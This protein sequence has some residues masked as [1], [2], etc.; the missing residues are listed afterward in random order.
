MEATK[1]F[2]KRLDE[3]YREE[4]SPELKARD[5]IAG[6]TDDRFLRLATELLLPKWS[7]DTF[8][9]KGREI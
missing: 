1:L 9:T 2:L 8:M 7:L 5:M 3:K 4:T 6:L